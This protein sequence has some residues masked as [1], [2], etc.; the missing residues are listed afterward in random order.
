M[1]NK[2]YINEILYFS[3]IFLIFFFVSISLVIYFDISRHWTN[4]YDQEFTLAYNALLFN[5][6][7]RQEFLVH[8]GYFT[9]LFLSIFILL[10]KLFQFLDF[11]NIFGLLNFNDIDPPLQNLISITRIYAGISLAAWC[12][13]INMIFY[14]F[15]NTKIYSLFL[16]LILLTFPGTF[17][18]AFE[19]RTELMASIFMILSFLSM[20]KYLDHENYKNSKINLFFFFIFI[21]CAILNKSQ[22]FFYLFGIIILC[23][24]FYKKINQLNLKLINNSSEKYFYYTYLIIIIYLFL[25]LSIY[26]GTTYLSLVF[27]ICNLALLN[28]IFYKITK[29][30][31][32]DSVKFLTNFNIILISSFLILK[33]ILFFHPST[34]ELA[35]INT[36]INILGI[37]KYSIYA[38]ENNGNYNELINIFSIFILHLKKVFIY[39]FNEVNIYNILIIT[40]LILSLVF[41]RNIGNKLFI[42]NIFCILI[43]LSFAFIS[44]FKSIQIVYHIFW[45][46]IFLLPFC[47][48]CKK[49]NFNSNLLILFIFIPIL[50][51]NFIGFKNFK[52]NI[53]QKSNM[54]SAYEV[55]NELALNKENYLEAFHKK[56]PVGKFNNFC[57]KIKN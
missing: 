49:I 10:A 9:I 33:L 16:S 32:I 12:T 5:S 54:D 46:F 19:L 47:I 11:Y 52:I 57:N 7:I 48:F 35:F 45:D 17:I 15:S 30:E 6:G 21:Y 36:L 43:P 24:F 31:K 29:I 55:C 20:L 4:I 1:N 2:K 53:I 22:I 44:S 51:Y 26:P 41:K 13:V 56:I 42:F 25:K 23:L 50:I 34:N 28:F 40:I 27:I 38:V 14:Y 39:F 8:S 3:F 37:S 18:H